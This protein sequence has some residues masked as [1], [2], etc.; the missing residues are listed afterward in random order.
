VL[1]NDDAVEQLLTLTDAEVETLAIA[2]HERWTADRLRRGW[3][4]G[5]RDDGRRTHA[6]LVAWEQ[7]PPD[8][9]EIDRALVRARPTLLARAGFALSRAGRAGPA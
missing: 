1:P 2:E 7:L 3:A 6:D 4:L 5:P 9:K 8:S